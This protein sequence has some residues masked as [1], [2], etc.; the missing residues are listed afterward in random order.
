[1]KEINIMTI[2]KSG[3]GRST[4]ISVIFGNELVATNIEKS[5][6][7]NTYTLPNNHLTIYDFKIETGNKDVDNLY[8]LIDKQNIDVCWYCV[9]AGGSRIDPNEINIINNIAKKN[10][11]IIVATQAIGGTTTKEFVK[12]IESEF[13]DSKIDVIPVMALPK[14]QESEYGQMKIKEHSID[15]LVAKSYQLLPKSKREIFITNQKIDIDLK[16][17]DNKIDSDNKADNKNTETKTTDD[18]KTDSEINITDN[19]KIE[20]K[21]E[22]NDNEKAEIKT[23]IDKKV[24][25]E[26]KISKAKK[27]S[28]TYSAAVAVS[29][30]QPFPIADAPIMIGIQVGMMAHITNCFDIPISKLDFSS[31]LT[32]I[33]TPF[34]AALVGRAITS[35]WKFIPIIG[36]L[37]GGLINASTGA[38]LTL[39]IAN[40]YIETLTIALKENMEINEKVIIN[41]LKERM[42]NIDNEIIEKEWQANKNNVSKSDVDEILENRKK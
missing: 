32:G 2:G 9:N 1:M 19:E 10:K 4:L 11:V 29:S 16:N 30:F 7:Y 35:L 34:I 37:A 23:T 26:M 13:V 38:V 39:A 40:I 25:I 17:I 28:Y 3:V 15:K 36:T 24:N 22:T 12:A 27:I 31:I 14:I 5:T 8:K 33:G 21:T 20:T 6:I 42:K 18:K 41:G